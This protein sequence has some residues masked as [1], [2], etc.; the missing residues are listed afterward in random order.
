M[1]LF[2]TD[3]AI[4]LSSPADS[5]LSS[6]G[7]YFL[8][9]KQKPKT[10]DGEGDRGRRQGITSS[11]SAAAGYDCYAVQSLLHVPGKDTGRCEH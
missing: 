2:T 8:Y 11:R 3:A 6:S 7:S 10:L 9:Y 1:L 5:F 4:S